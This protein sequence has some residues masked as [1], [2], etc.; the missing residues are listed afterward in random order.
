MRHC[1]GT[2]GY[3]QPDLRIATPRIRRG[4]L[5]RMIPPLEM[6]WGLGDR[7]DAFNGQQ[8]YLRVPGH[9]GRTS[10]SVASNLSEPE[11]CIDDTRYDD[12][13]VGMERSIFP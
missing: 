6:T 9:S 5:S 1:R 8:T 7:L 11:S 12:D 13:D 2:C 10:P 3:L 4:L